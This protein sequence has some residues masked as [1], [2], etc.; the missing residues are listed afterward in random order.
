MRDH[1]NRYKRSDYSRYRKEIKKQ[2]HAG[3]YFPCTLFAESSMWSSTRSYMT[4]SPG[5]IT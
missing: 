3:D 2:E 4:R 5:M 1:L